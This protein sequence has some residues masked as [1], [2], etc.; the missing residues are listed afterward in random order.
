MKANVVPSF[1][2][3][4][5]QSPWSHECSG[6]FASSHLILI[7]ASCMIEGHWLKKNQNHTQ[8]WSL[9]LLMV[10][11]FSTC[12]RTLTT[13]HTHNLVETYERNIEHRNLQSVADR[14]NCHWNCGSFISVSKT[15][16]KSKQKSYFGVQILLELPTWT[17]T[18]RK[19]NFGPKQIDACW[20]RSIIP[21]HVCWMPDSRA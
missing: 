16:Q 11:V 17:L 10:S 8:E 19:I 1:S 7:F 13:A 3:I 2:Y 15:N 20:S 12:V 21:A 14:R 4:W 6:V 5:H 9:L 18:S